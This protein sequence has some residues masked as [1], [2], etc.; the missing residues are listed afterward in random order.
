MRRSID[1]TNRQ[2]LIDIFSSIFV[3]FNSSSDRANLIRTLLA[4]HPTSERVLTHC[5]FAGDPLGVALHNVTTLVEWEDA[6]NRRAISYAIDSLI[7]SEQTYIYKFDDVEKLQKIKDSLPWLWGNSTKAPA[8]KV[9]RQLKSLTDDNASSVELEA[10]FNAGDLVHMYIFDRALHAKGAVIKIGLD[11]ESGTGFLIGSD[12]IMTNHHVLKTREQAE[13]A[14]YIFFYELDNTGKET[15]SHTSRALQGG[16]FYTKPDETKPDFL[17][18][19]IV[20]LSDVPKSVTP[21]KLRERLPR[22]GQYISMIQHPEGGFK[23][24]AWRRNNQVE[25]VQSNRQTIMY[26]LASNQGSSGAP[27]FNDDFEVI[28]LHYGWE[29]EEDVNL[30]IPTVG[31]ISDLR[32]NAPDI[33]KRLTVD[34]A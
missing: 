2:I 34:G 11:N 22:V 10:Y 1:Q 32:S 28:A 5:V 4:N 18:F 7:Q 21:L 13:A 30:A 8:L 26:R 6:F 15:L 33:L 24:I 20:Q 23:K 17:D 25:A 12:L 3:N 27:V 16:I 9:P 19:S 29:V 31:I 14:K